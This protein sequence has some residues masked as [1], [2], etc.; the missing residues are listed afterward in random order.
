MLA[1]IHLISLTDTGD[2]GCDAAV[3]EIFRRH[4][5]NTPG[6]MAFACSR[7]DRISDCTGATAV[8]QLAGK[9]A[10]AFKSHLT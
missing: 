4:K 7:Q 3:L 6:T 5:L 9:I 8:V 10:F 1:D 2:F